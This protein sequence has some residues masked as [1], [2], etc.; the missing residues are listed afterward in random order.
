MSNELVPIEQEFPVLAQDISHLS[1]VIRENLGDEGIDRFALERL[2]V[3]SG[4]APG[5]V[6]EAPEQDPDVIKSFEA[7]VVHHQ[8]ERKFYKDDDEGDETGMGTPP[9]CLSFDAK[10]GFGDNGTGESGAHN[11][12]TC[13][14]AQWGTS[15]KGKGQACKLVRAVYLYR[16]GAE[17]LFPSLLFVPTGSVKVWSKFA[18]DLT[19]RGVKLKEQLIEFTT[20]STKNDAGKPYSLVKPRRVRALSEADAELMK[21]LLTSMKGLVTVKA[22]TSGAPHESE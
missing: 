20:E 15:R 16:K 13:P 18:S 2:K 8:E 7:I 21:P 10:T 11:C 5:F 4:G 1:E 3:Q 22:P 9:D 19:M 12:A 6:V 17:T 14:Q